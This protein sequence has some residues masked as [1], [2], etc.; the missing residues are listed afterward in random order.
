MQHL[1]IRILA[2]LSASALP[3]CAQSI[4]DSAGVRVVSYPGV[5]RPVARW[6]VDARPVVEVGGVDGV[7]PTEFADIMGAV[8]LPNGNIVVAN[9]RTNELRFFDRAGKF[10][11]AAGRTG[12]GPGE[13]SQLMSVRFSGNVL[14]AGDGM[15]GLRIFGADGTFERQVPTSMAGRSQRAFLAFADGSSLWQEQEPPTDSLWY[16]R[17]LRIDAD[18]RSTTLQ[19]FPVGEMVAGPPGRGPTHVEFSARSALAVLA[20]RICRGWSRAYEISCYDFAGRQMLVIRRSVPD[21]AVSASVRKAF[22]DSYTDVSGGLE[23]NHSAEAMAGLK[24]L[25]LRNLPGLVYAKSLPTFA[26]FLG[27]QANELWVRDFRVE[28]AFV[29]PGGFNP[30]PTTSTHWNVFAADGR[31]IAD[32]TLP[33]RFTAFDAGTD[34]VLGVSRDAEDVERVTMLRL[35]R[36]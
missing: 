5:A 27:S 28:D 3:L 2:A 17:L 29:R 11:K 8:R 20:D 36:K 16:V 24:A 26:S 9:M 34:Y 23:G 15:G 33:P 1:R 31:W 10:I 4:H 25:R 6:R 19:R 7:G 35:L 12:A 13:F 21:V 32:V 18:G 14:Q 30:P 22:E